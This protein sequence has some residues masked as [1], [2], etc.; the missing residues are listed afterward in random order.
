MRALVLFLLV[1]FLTSCVSFPGPDKASGRYARAETGEFLDFRPNGVFYYSI[2]L[3]GRLTRNYKGEPVMGRY[4]LDR[5]GGLHLSLVS[6]HA[7]HFR[8]RFSAGKDEVF[9]DR[10]PEREV[11]FQR[12][13]R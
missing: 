4:S 9:L 3:D 12:T 6:I 11:A 1:V 10:N 8:L 7:G 13:T 5:S 2:L